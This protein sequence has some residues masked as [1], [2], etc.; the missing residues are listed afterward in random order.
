MT[1]PITA[2]WSPTLTECD[3]QRGGAHPQGGHDH[4]SA[5]VEPERPNRRH[6]QFHGRCD[7]LWHTEL[8]VAEEPGQPEQRRALFGLYDGDADR[9]ERRQQRCGQLSLRGHRRLRQRHLQP[10]DA[11]R[12][13]RADDHQRQLRQ[14]RRPGGIPGGVAYAEH[15]PGAEH[16]AI[17]QL[18]EVDLQCGRHDRPAE[19]AEFH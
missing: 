14:L 18:A 6:G 4:H 10:G 5:P 19:P 2:A 9:V 3:L 13:Q 1:S 17:P 8:P 7:G 15:E 11:D 16:D 12:N